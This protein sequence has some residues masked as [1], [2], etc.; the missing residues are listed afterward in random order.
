MSIRRAALVLV[1]LTLAPTTAAAH[2]GWNGYDAS[3]PVTL[4]GTIREAG[5]EHPHG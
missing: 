5:Y 3:K 2:H 1:T 4:E